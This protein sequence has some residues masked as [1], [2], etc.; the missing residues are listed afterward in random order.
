ML[1]REKPKLVPMNE[2][3]D[4]SAHLV[5]GAPSRWADLCMEESTEV[6]Q[7]KGSGIDSKHYYGGR[8]SYGKSVIFCG[9]GASGD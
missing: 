5:Q 8:G 3:M 1:L 4:L 2:N 9:G 7:E 6:L